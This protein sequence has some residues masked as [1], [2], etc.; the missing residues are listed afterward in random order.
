MLNYEGA[1]LDWLLGL[2]Y[3]LQMNMSFLRRGFTIS[4]VLGVVGVVLVLAAI[5]I[6]SYRNTNSAAKE[7]VSVR[8]AETLN[9]AVQQFDQSGGLMTARVIVPPNISSLKSPS[10]LP[11]MRV[12]NLLRDANSSSSGELVSSWQ[13]PVFSD[14]GYRVVWE[15][16]LSDVEAAKS[17]TTIG[18]VRNADAEAAIAAG[19][20]GRFV[21]LTPETQVGRI[22]IVGFQEAPLIAEAPAPTP[23][24]TQAP[25]HVVN[26]T[27]SS[28]TAGTVTGNGSYVHG[29]TATISVTLNP[30]WV[31]K[32]WDAAVTNLLGGSTKLNG[33]FAV[34]GPVTGTMTVE[35][36]DLSVNLSVTPISAGTTTGGGSYKYGD[37][38]NFSVTPTPGWR[39]KS[40]GNPAMPAASGRLNNVTSDINAT[41]TM[42]VESYTLTMLA[43]TGGSANLAPGQHVFNYN[44]SVPLVATPIWSTTMNEPRYRWDRWVVGSSVETRQ[45]FTHVM[46]APVSIQPIFVRQFLLEVSANNSSWGSVTSTSPSGYLDAGAQVGINAA[47]SPSYA[48]VRWDVS[49]DGA[50]WGALTSAPNRAITLNRDTKLRAVFRD[51]CNVNIRVVDDAGRAVSGGVSLSGATVGVNAF[52]IGSSQAIAFTPVAGWGVVRV[53]GAPVVASPA[54][55][56][57]S[58]GTINLNVSNDMDVTIVVARVY[59]L[60]VRAMDALTEKTLNVPITGPGVMLAGSQ[61]ITVGEDP[62]GY[63]FLGWYAESTEEPVVEKYTKLDT[64]RALTYDLTQ[65]SEIIAMFAPPLTAGITASPATVYRDQPTTLKATANIPSFIARTYAFSGGVQV[66]NSPSDDTKLVT[67]DVIGTQT[68]SVVVTDSS[69]RTAIASTGV[70][71]MNRPP[72]LTL[73]VPPLVGVNTKFQVTAIASDPDEDQLNYSFAIPNSPQNGVSGPSP[74]ITTEVTATGTQTVTATVSDG[75]ST[76]SASAPLKVMG[77]FTLT[78]AG[79]PAAWGYAAGGGSFPAGSVTQVTPVPYYGYEFAG[80]AGGLGASWPLSVTMTDNKTVT[81]TFTRR[82]FAVTFDVGVG[83]VL[84]ARADVTVRSSSGGV[85]SSVSVRGA[86][87][88]NIERH[89]VYVPYG[90]TVYLD[91]WGRVNTDHMGASW[92]SGG[93]TEYFTRTVGGMVTKGG[94]VWTAPRRGGRG[95]QWATWQEWATWQVPDY[96]M[97]DKNFGTVTAKTVTGDMFLGYFTI[98]TPLM[99]DLSG[100]AKPDLMAGPEWRKLDDRVP[101]GNLKDF[102]EFDLDGSGKK[103]WEWV[104]TNDGLLVYTKGLAGTPTA[105]NLFGGKTFGKTWAHGY[106]PLA[107][108]DKDGDK[109]ITGTELA[110]IGVWQDKNSDAVAQEGEI[111]PATDRGITEI[112]LVFLEDEHGNVMAVDG[113]KVDGKPAQV[114]DWMSYSYPIT[115]NANEVARI[116]WTNEEPKS[117]FFQ[118]TVGKGME[119][120]SM[121]PGGTLKVYKINGQIFI[122]AT[123]KVSPDSSEVMDV[124]Y[125]ATLSPEGILEWGMSDTRNTLLPSGDELFGFTVSGANKYAIWSA[126]LVSGDLGSLIEQPKVTILR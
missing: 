121:L 112:S 28:P 90:D 53:A 32:S 15:N 54:G 68:A 63:Q 86:G 1:S 117:E 118:P 104:G 44:D 60:G 11:E 52:R 55:L 56:L 57:N 48:F 64:A 109:K 38:V 50:T 9:S 22:G 111:L 21:V 108:L 79:S 19:E 4:E 51:T 73:Q 70:S 93:S 124:L 39:F 12:L 122:R 78:T 33:S 18:G 17:T 24:P 89:T 27:L 87:T 91:G 45:S 75:L 71:V 49:Y 25:S 8:N 43:G 113:A 96:G 97:H 94:M 34:T 76:V 99:V 83:T 47:A 77:N 116:D 20:G 120:I 66:S 23:E 2:V 42:E 30:G 41:A 6:P 95:W 35:R 100:D 7:S 59:T 110:D 37:S 107:T 62:A 29:S 13:E 40:W 88:T 82:L 69:G 61:T 16:S 125:P 67:F 46:G 74:T 3:N 123:A 119:K 36:A 102:R 92:E 31:V 114:W 103:L 72:V 106:E 84:G 58:G 101:S 65:D 105:N 14:T 98:G 126:K 81:A 5:A 80:W 85:L 10:E 26:L 115:S